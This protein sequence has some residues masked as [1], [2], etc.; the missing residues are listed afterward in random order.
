MEFVNDS[1]MWSRVNP[2]ISNFHFIPEFFI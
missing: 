1:V 2:S